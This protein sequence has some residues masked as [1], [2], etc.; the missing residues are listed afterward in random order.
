MKSI[1]IKDN[2]F[3][4][5][6]V[7]VN[8]LLPL[9]KEDMSK[10][11]LIAMVLKKSSKKYGTEKELER[12]LAKLYNASLRVNVEKYAKYYNIEFGIEVIN[13]KYIDKDVLEEALNVLKEIIYN[14]NIKDKAFNK[15]LVEREK[16]GLINIIN[17]QKDQKRTYAI[18]KVEE[19]LFENEDYG[20]PL[21]GKEE[22]YEKI[23]EKSL[24]EHYRKI[25]DTAEI[26]VIVNGN[27]EGYENIDEI[28]NNTFNL[29]ANVNKIEKEE[30]KP[31]KVDEPKLYEEKQDISQSV[32]TFG[33]RLLDV[34]KDNV[35]TAVVLNAIL[36]GTPSSKLFQNIRE[37]QS[38]AYFAK[39][40]YNKQK[41]AICIAAGIE[42]KNYL[43]AKELIQKE[44][45]DLRNGVITDEE[46]ITA[47]DYVVS[48]YKEIKDSKVGYAK[49]ILSNTIL[50]DDVVDIDEIIQKIE[51]LQKEDVLKV[52]DKVNVQ[53]IYL[54]GGR[55]ND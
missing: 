20:Y 30:I 26:K 33:I 11:A 50:Y 25:L 18:N 6:F 2:K 14:P 43:K 8:L 40:L 27:V 47:R 12:K 3:K 45:D 53:T 52:A 34:E 44:I 7:S 28:I 21:L 22:D 29:Y 37:K 17:E 41:N 5:V 39:S 16:E 4:S 42:P 15:T 1:V 13:K 10:N 9:V 46:F 55:E 19:Y 48:T 23:D 31:V 54:L 38:L 24:Y 36:G 51:K 35:H 32:L 49:F